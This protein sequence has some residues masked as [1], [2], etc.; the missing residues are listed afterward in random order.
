MATRAQ[1]AMVA[2]RSVKNLWTRSRAL[3]TSHREIF[4]GKDT[5]KPLR[6]TSL[7]R[8]IQRKWGRSTPWTAVSR[9]CRIRRL[10]QFRL[11]TWLAAR[12]ETSNKTARPKGQSLIPSSKCRTAV[13]TRINTRVSLRTSPMGVS[14]CTLS[15]TQESTRTRTARGEPSR[16]WGA[17][18]ATQI[19]SLQIWVP[20]QGDSQASLLEAPTKARE[21]L[22]QSMRTIK[23]TWTVTASLT[24]LLKKMDL[25][26]IK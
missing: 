3:L 5:A 15:P 9:N 17:L 14:H 24:I 1:T 26:A 8:W 25:S 12:L 16:T 18:E 10:I 2:I 19:T 13:A 23:A 20:M 21:D 4:L 6:A 22:D 11:K 7:H